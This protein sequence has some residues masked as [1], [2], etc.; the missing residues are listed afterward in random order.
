[1]STFQFE[2]TPK[3]QLALEQVTLSYL[4]PDSPLP[5]VVR[6]A[7]EGINLIQWAATNASFIES[8]LLRNGAILFRDF[9][10]SKVEEFERLIEAVSGRVLDHS[11]RST[12]RQILNGRVY[13]STEYPAH[14]SIP[15][16]NHNSYTRNWPMRLSF[17]SL[18]VAELGGE[19]PLA[20][21]RKILLN[22]PAEIR[23]CFER[24][25][26]MYVRNYG[27]GLDLSWQEVF[28][29][30]SKTVVEDYC[31]KA[32]L[33]FEWIGEEQIR[34]RQRAQA[35]AVHPRTGERVWFNQAHLFHVSMLPAEVRQW[36]LVAYSEQNLPRNVYFS[37]GSAIDPAM[38]DEISRIYE[39]QLVVFPWRQGDVL[40]LDNMLTAHGRRP[41][42]GKRKVVVG[43]SESNLSARVSSFETFGGRS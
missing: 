35:V 12:F 8:Y 41:F 18:H 29:T 2:K 38:L 34:T 22:M 23:E 11:H 4:R 10:L 39:E 7:V 9:G 43:T 24:K 37:D 13:S 28:Q 5:L 16:H 15:L 27:T 3:E 20:D 25:G 1:M 6:P 36:L 42:V 33:E 17:F 26:L 30:S 21:S 40:M 32:Q 14:Q 19:T 31:R